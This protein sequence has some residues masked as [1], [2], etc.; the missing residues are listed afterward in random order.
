MLFLKHIICFL[1]IN[2]SYSFNNLNLLSRRNI[3]KDMTL[4]ASHNLYS[5]TL[6]SSIIFDN[7]ENYKFQINKQENL[8]NNQNDLDKQNTIAI[9]HKNKNNLFFTG[10][11][12]DETCTNINDAL[13]NYKNKIFLSGDLDQHINLYIQSPGGSLMPTLALVDE[14]KNFPIPIYTYVRGYAASAATLL[15]VVGKKRFIYKHSI[16][17]VHS[18]KYGGAEVNSLLDVKDLNDNT[19]LLMS[20][21][22]EI[23]LE[24]TNLSSYQLNKMFM[25][26]KWMNSKSALHYGLVDEI[27]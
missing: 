20:I 3:L 22:K 1:L 9:A 5:N 2:P 26:D 4:L 13:L 12:T 19:D 21:I 16:M 8:N 18:I 24:N 14:I 6:N 27:L 11:L 15:S 25:H 23:Y 17:M 7:N 10:T